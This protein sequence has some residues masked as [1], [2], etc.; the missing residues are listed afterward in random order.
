MK[1]KRCTCSLTRD[2][3]QAPVL[4]DGVLATEPQVSPSDT[5]TFRMYRVR[6]AGRVLY[7]TL[8]S[9]SFIRIDKT[10]TKHPSEKVACG[11][12]PLNGRSTKSS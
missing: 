3:I 6:S 5:M 9:L 4:G 12:K 7:H 2:Q 10:V 11:K 8:E 1:A